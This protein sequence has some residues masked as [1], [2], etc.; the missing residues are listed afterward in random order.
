MQVLTDHWASAGLMHARQ[1][2]LQELQQQARIRASEQEQGLGLLQDMPENA[3]QVRHVQLPI[4]AVHHR[5]Q[6]A[7]SLPTPQE[8]VQD[9]DMPVVCHLVA[10][11][12]W[13]RVM[14]PTLPAGTFY[15]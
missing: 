15:W 12:S 2:R 8:L 9:T 6:D 13:V 7:D 4:R 14:A 5:R 1:S 10:E 3:L 11:S